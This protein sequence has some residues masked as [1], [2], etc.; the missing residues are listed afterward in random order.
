MPVRLGKVYV[1]GGEMINFY[2]DSAYAIAKLWIDGVPYDLPSDAPWPQPEEVFVEKTDVYVAGS[3]YGYGD[4]RAV[5]WKN[6]RPVYL[7]KDGEGGQAHSLYVSNKDVYVSG[8]VTR[9]GTF[10]A[11]IWKNGVELFQIS[12]TTFL[13]SLFVYNNDLYATGAHKVNGIR[14]PAIYKNGQPQLLELPTNYLDGEV[15]CVYVH[16][17]IV[18]AAGY[19][20][21]PLKN[22]AALW[23]NG[24]YT[25]LEGPGNVWATGVTV[26]ATNDVFVTGMQNAGCAT[27][28]NGKI[29]YTENQFSSTGASIT[30][31]GKDVYV[32][33]HG[34]EAILWKNNIPNVLP[35][36]KGIGYAY[37]V[38]VR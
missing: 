17:G 19:V 21:M 5:L 2:T 1:A 18:Y 10:N 12:D 13:W 37:S 25:E 4:S 23:I 34:N 31:S 14:Y 27:W 29:L 20:S 30:T 8:S 32:A 26:S 9:N 15:L 11:V 16:K 6:M 35:V 24:K 3:E 22:E 33:S 38:F 28:K 7:S 36:K